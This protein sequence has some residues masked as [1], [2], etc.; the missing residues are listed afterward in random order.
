MLNFTVQV[1]IVNQILFLQLLN[2]GRVLFVLF[3]LV[4]FAGNGLAALYFDRDLTTF[5][6]N[7]YKTKN[8]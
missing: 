5:F 1:L 6:L 3:G 4:I 8:A 2:L 7:I